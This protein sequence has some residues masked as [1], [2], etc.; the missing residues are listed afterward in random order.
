ME[1]KEQPVIELKHIHKSFRL[2]DKKNHR[3]REALHP[4]RKK[5]H[6]EFKALH[7]VDLKIY[8]G[9]IVG[10]LG[11]NGSGKS[12]LLKVIAGVIQPNRGT[13]QL[14]GRVVPLLE[15]GAGFNPEFTG[16]ENIYFYNS[17]QGFSKKQTDAM[18]DDILDF[19]EI[20]VFID[21]PLKTY[22]SGMR[23]RLGFAVSVY[24]DPEILILDE[25]FAV[26][27]EIF[28]RKCHNKMLEF[29]KQGKT[30]LYVTHSIESIKALCTR[31]VLLHQGELLLDGP[32]ELV[33]R[34]YNRLGKVH[35]DDVD[36]WVEELRAL[37]QRLTNPTVPNATLSAGQT[38]SVAAQTTQSGTPNQSVPKTPIPLEALQPIYDPA[39]AS[40]NSAQ[41]RNQMVAI[42]GISIYTKDNIPVN[43][44]VS[45]QSY[46]MEFTVT[47]EQTFSKIG[48]SMMVSN[49]QVNP[50]F[51][52][53]TGKM[54]KQL[55]HVVQGDRIQLRWTFDCV[56][57]Q[58]VYFISL[59][60]A[61]Q[62][63]MPSE[64]MLLI[65]IPNALAFRV[66][67]Q[68]IGDGL[69]DMKFVPTFTKLD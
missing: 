11:R 52:V 62:G 25:V 65:S 24:I 54:G 12:T 14:R 59:G 45:G 58:G 1:P 38:S 53:F 55:P 26:G 46:I 40:Q 63:A 22:S 7:D 2:Y 36:L 20:G 10:I 50:I 5:Y 32:T 41:T 42:S 66:V 68:Q 43:V 64:R 60:A 69:V 16:R 17:I 51:R 23:A 33:A 67:D 4:F 18:L 8:K 35:A 27:D 31:A 48:F 13:V 3:V 57:F 39:L 15:L 6:E 29:F 47:F 34:E 30:I 56:L 49:E 21:Q 28:R 37:N 9:E 61:A 44:L 19:A